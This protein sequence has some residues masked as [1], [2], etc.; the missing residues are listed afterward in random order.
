MKLNFRP[1]P[2]AVPK[3]YKEVGLDYEKK[4]I[5]PA[6]QE[7]LKAET[8][9]HSVVEI[10][11]RRPDMKASVQTKMKTWLARYDIDLEEVAIAEVDFDDDYEKAI[12]AKQV[13]E[14]QAL[15]KEYQ[16][17]MAKQDAEIARTTAKGQADSLRSKGEGEAEYNRQ[18]SASL[19][20]ALV[21]VKGVE[22][23]DGKYPTY[24]GSGS[25]GGLFLT[26]PQGK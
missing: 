17:Q 9:L 16:L 26:M 11:R 2:R 21:E 3:L 8:A 13:Q 12:R 18:V 19:T 1:S 24:M 23:W 14:Q 7:V 4:V 15:A 5:D 10:L 22:K 6:S 20:S 25:G